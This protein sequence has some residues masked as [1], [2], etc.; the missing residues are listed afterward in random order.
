MTEYFDLGSL[1]RPKFQLRSLPLKI[2][3]EVTRRHP[4]YQA[5]WRSFKNKIGSSSETHESYNQW[6][7]KLSDFLLGAI[8]IASERPNPATE[9]A[10]LEE[11]GY[12]KA[13]WLSG[14]VHPLTNR[15]LAALLMVVLPKE[16]LG[17]VGQGMLYA[18]HG[19]PVDGEPRIALEMRNLQNP[20]IGW[21]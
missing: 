1:A 21:A 15:Q 14:A 5:F 7:G 13:A 11:D 12:S 4:V 20:R 9:F 17:Y 6:I 2:R 8:G 16:T 19:E 18:A 3:W 10:K